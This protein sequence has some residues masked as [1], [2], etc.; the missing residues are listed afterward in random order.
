[1]KEEKEKSEKSKA[2]IVAMKAVT[3]QAKVAAKEEEFKA[4]KTAVDK[5][6]K[7]FDPQAIFKVEIAVYN[8]Q[9]KVVKEAA[10]AP[11]AGTKPTESE[12]IKKAELPKINLAVQVIN[13][14]KIEAAKAKKE[15]EKAE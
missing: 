15:Q 7:L 12:E 1:M 3:S 8:A 10:K 14:A 2:T 4:K 9:K 13:T 11:P 5:A 6:E